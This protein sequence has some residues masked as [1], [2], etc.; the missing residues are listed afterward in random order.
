ML[1]P[2]MV[3]MSWHGGGGDAEAQ[4]DYKGHTPIGIK[5]GPSSSWLYPQKDGIG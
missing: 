1:Y 2:D 5:A 4:Q 3:E